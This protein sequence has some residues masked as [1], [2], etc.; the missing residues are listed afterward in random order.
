MA[1][2]LLQPVLWQQP[3]ILSSPDDALSCFLGQGCN[4]SGKKK[5][6]GISAALPQS[7]HT[8]SGHRD[9]VLKTDTAILYV[10]SSISVQFYLRIHYLLVELFQM[11]SEAALLQV[12]H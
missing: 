3:D 9:L 12:Y 8:R 11:N 4:G 1:V 6:S 5:S 2:L 7:C 10:C